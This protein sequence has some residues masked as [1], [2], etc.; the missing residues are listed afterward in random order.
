MGALLRQDVVAA[1]CHAVV[2]SVVF[3]GAR[4]RKDEMPGRK[5]AAG[6]IVLLG[7]R[8]FIGYIDDDRYPFAVCVLVEDIP[9][10]K[11]GGNTA[12]P[13]AGQIFQYLKAHPELV[14]GQ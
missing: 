11:S 5:G 7:G 4:R 13:I 14:S 6:G 10:G 2:L 3:L 1:D 12:A 9:D 8:L